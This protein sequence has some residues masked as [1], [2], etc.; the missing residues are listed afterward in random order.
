MKQRKEATVSCRLTDEEKAALE[1]MA[2][3]KDISLSK[4]VRD[5]IKDYLQEDQK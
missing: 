5:I 3:R 2:E 4:L 1:A